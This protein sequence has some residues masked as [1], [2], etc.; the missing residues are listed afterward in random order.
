MDDA[1][2]DESVPVI[3]ECISK[4]PQIGFLRLFRNQGNCK[5]FNQALERVEGDFIIDLAADDVLLPDRIRQGVMAL[6]RAGQ[7]YGV[8][9]TDAAWISEDGRQLYRHSDRFPHHTI[10]Q[11]DVYGD[12]IARFF[13]CSPS[14]MFRREVV[15]ALG[16]YDESLDYEDFDFW[17][18]SSREFRYCYTPEVLVKKRVVRNS[19]SE[20]QFV[21]WGR[22]LRSTFR[23][24][25]KVMALNRSVAEQRSLQKR[26]L[27]EMGV[28]L[29]LLHLPLFMKYV[30]LYI[31]NKKQQYG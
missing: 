30:A 5:A 16:G 19:M 10:P 3:N 8:H 11:G 22:Q 15:E 31:S 4:H 9:F 21:F 18:R 13:I 26:I 28:C 24:C 12:L 7:D 20:R 2:T 25:E 29:R 1:S 17:I 23:V 6:H 27:Y 14:M